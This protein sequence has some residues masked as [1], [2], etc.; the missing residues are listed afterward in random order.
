MTKMKIKQAKKHIRV[1]GKIRKGDQVIAITGNDKGQ[2]GT[3]LSRKGE[4]AVVQ[5]L[6][7]R[8]KHVKATQN[9]PGSI[10]SLE[11]PIH[12]SNLKICVEGKPVKLK[13]RTSEEGERQFVYQ[14][15][16]QEVVYRSVK[17]PK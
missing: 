2:I 16:D 12:I 15:G 13:I 3:V 14:K 5:G 17:K 8:K 7:V 1:V 10:I 11:M 6:N 9:A 4:R